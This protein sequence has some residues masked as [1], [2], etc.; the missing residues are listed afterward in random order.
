MP[1]A[2]NQPPTYARPRF[3]ISGGPRSVRDLKETAIDAAKYLKHVQ[4]HGE[5]S[6]RDMRDNTVTVSEGEKS[7]PWI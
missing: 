1:Q 7:F 4:P 5:V 6:V 2:T 3:W